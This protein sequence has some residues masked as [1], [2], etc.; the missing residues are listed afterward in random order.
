MG[1]MAMGWDVVFVVVKCVRTTGL[2]LVFGVKC[3][4][5]REP[6]VAFEVVS[7]ILL[8]VAG[9]AEVVVLVAAFQN[10]ISY[11]SKAPCLPSMAARLLLFMFVFLRWQLAWRRRSYFPP[12]SR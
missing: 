1:E 10:D 6:Q 4:L 7:A 5:R 11:P 8:L 12:S 3:C 2:V 9:L